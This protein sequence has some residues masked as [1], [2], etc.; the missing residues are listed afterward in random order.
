[1][2]VICLHCNRKVGEVA[3]FDSKVG[4]PTLCTSCL[5]RL[6]EKMSEARPRLRKSSL[7]RFDPEVT[8]VSEV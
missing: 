3:A 2:R 8:S 6:R 1:M 5:K 7:W 4:G